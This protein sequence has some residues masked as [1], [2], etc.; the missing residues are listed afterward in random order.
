VSDKL[1]TKTVDGL[2]FAVGFA[3]REA[4]VS[5]VEL[6]KWLEFAGLKELRHLIESHSVELESYG[7]LVWLGGAKGQKQGHRHAG[8]YY[9]NEPQALLV[10]MFSRTAKSA[11]VRRMLIVAFGKVKK[12]VQRYEYLESRILAF[13][14]RRHWERLWGPSV[15]AE[16][17]RIHRW[18]TVGSTGQMFAP[19]RG[20]FDRLY[21]ILLGDEVVD[22][23]KKRNPNPRRGQNHHQLLQEKVR[24]MI[25]N[26][27]QLIEIFARQSATTDEWTAKLRA[28]F[29]REPYQLSF[30][31]KP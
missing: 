25:G 4:R 29:L 9:L 7:E 1:S 22:E 3:D 26:D 17:C 2:N 13:D 8:H 27:V 28:H 21:R 11:D 31:V 20:V 15:V 19:L 23:I 10:A 5:D 6:A 30:E 12:D 24:E 14:E 16:I 18:P